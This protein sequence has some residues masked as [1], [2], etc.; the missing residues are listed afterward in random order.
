MD[1]DGTLVDSRA[2]VERAWSA[3]LADAGHLP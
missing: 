2:A 1:M 3:P